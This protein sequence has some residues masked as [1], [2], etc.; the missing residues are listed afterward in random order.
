M[1]S[2]YKE[3][4]LICENLL[5]SEEF[6]QLQNFLEFQEPNI[7]QILGISK[8][9]ERI[10][11]FLAWLLNPQVGHSF[12]DQFLK[13]LLVR[14]LQTDIGREKDITPVDVLVLDLSTVSVKTEFYIDKRRCDIVVYSLQKKQ[15]ALDKE[16]GLICIIENKIAARE[17]DNQTVD[18]YQKSL[19]KFSPKDYP[20][21]IY[22]YLSPDGN[23]SLDD[24]FIPLSYRDIY[25]LIQ[26]LTSD[27]EISETE[28]FLIGQFQEN[29]S[30]GIVMDSQLLDLAQQVY[31]QHSNVFEFVIQN[32][33]RSSFEDFSDALK[34]WDGRS[35]FFNIGEKPD[36]RYRWVDCREYGFICAGGG[37]LYKNWMEKFQADDIIYAYVSG[38]GY[39]GVGTITRVAC[40]FR[41]A[42]LEDGSSFNDLD[43]EGDYN[44]ISDDE[45]CDWVALVDW[46]YDVPKEQAVRQPN[47]TRATTARIYE[48]RKDV[49]EAVREGLK[50]KAE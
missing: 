41:E 20:N 40:P 44:A 30:R 7:W 32:V 15:Q 43:L 12:G 8:R 35:R 36:S 25:E 26:E 50:E 33:S 1:N 34:E 27:Q 2:A 38:K 19:Q 16:K 18:Y 37:E 13:T 6:R 17:S 22:I 11:R 28:A 49:V 31:D 48:H 14:A 47:I 5:L 42:K 3:F 9:E 45:T 10:S 4:K 21:R 39:V 23:P 29:I 24:H 46:K